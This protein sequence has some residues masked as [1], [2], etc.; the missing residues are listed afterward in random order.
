MTPLHAARNA[1]LQAFGTAPT[2]AVQAPGRVNLIG[3]HTDYNDGFV[4]PCAI[5]YGTVICGEQCGQVP[6][7]GQ[8]TLLSKI[9]TVETATGLV[10]PSSALV[11]EAD[12]KLAIV[13]EHGERVPVKVVAGARG[14][15]VI[16]GV[17]TG[18]KVRVPG[19]PRQ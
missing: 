7:S 16:E 9:V 3:E 11:S 18:T 13:D 6:V 2:L 1:F 4:L 14:M 12:G 10:V 17:E 19:K 5:D 8:V 15:S